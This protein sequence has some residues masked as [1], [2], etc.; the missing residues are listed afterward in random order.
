[1]IQAKVKSRDFGKATMSIQVSQVWN[2][3]LLAKQIPACHRSLSKCLLRDTSGNSMT[4]MRKSKEVDI[5]LVCV[6]SG[7]LLPH[8]VVRKKRKILTECYQCTHL[9]L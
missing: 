6:Y 5:Q 8:Y 9:F 1:M 4:E 3:S 7:W 2:I